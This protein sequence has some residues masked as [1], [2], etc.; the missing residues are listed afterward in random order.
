MRVRL[1]VGVVLVLTACTP[2]TTRYCSEG[3]LPGTQCDV[4]T[5][6]CVRSEAPDSG[7]VVSGPA[8]LGVTVGSGGTAASSAYRLEAVIGGV[9]PSGSA[10][11]AQYKLTTVEE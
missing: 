9:A 1:G 2:S 11:S 7:P 8:T 4:A 5:Q 6:L 10:S 3:C